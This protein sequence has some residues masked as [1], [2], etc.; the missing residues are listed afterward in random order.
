[1]DGVEFL[2]NLIRD[3]FKY[4]RGSTITDGASTTLEI[5]SYMVDSVA[6]TATAE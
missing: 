1:M 6:S 4:F 2:K 5:T 3:Q